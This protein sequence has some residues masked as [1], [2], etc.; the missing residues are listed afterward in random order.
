MDGLN[1]DGS[2]DNEGLTV[3]VSNVIGPEGNE[4]VGVDAV[5]D[6][7]VVECPSQLPLLTETSSMA[8]SP[9]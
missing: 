3:T 9:S 5:G 7:G 8:K 1:V 2:G 4:R 6:A